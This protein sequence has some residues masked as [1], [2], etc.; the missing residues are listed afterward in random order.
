MIDELV[1]LYRY[2]STQYMKRFPLKYAAP[3]LG[4]R[5]EFRHEPGMRLVYA[6]HSVDW[7]FKDD[8]R[9]EVRVM[10]S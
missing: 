8:G 10:L 4:E 5:V 7:I 9:V 1:F 3:G 6:V 2:Q